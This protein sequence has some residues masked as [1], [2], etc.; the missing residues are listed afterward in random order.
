MTNA[1]TFTVTLARTLPNAGPGQDRVGV[2]TWNSVQLA[3]ET[4]NQ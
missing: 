4:F 2:Y 1:Y 3:G